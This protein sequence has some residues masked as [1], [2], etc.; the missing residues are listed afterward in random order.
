[1]GGGW[2]MISSD[3]ITINKQEACMLTRILLVDE[4]VPGEMMF[5]FTH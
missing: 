1:M 2:V 3:N 4:D 5:L